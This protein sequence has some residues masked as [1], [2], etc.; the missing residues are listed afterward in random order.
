MKIV[1]RRQL[2]AG[3][4]TRGQTA[5]SYT[6]F[7]EAIWTV[8]A[9]NWAASTRGRAPVEPRHRQVL[10]TAPSSPILL[11]PRFFAG[12][13]YGRET[14]SGTR[15]AQIGETVSGGRKGYLTPFLAFFGKS[16]TSKNGDC[17]SPPG[18]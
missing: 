7:L 11:T 4:E 15:F 16:Q 12:C 13:D 17:A 9:P 2:P 10:E 14:V 6:G 1:G 8:R 3:G 5:E 18:H